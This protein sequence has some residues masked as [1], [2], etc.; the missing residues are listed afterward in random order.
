MKT[1]HKMLKNIFLICAGSLV[2]SAAFTACSVP[3]QLTTPA[4]PEFPANYGLRQADTTQSETIQWKNYFKDK[5]LIQLIDYALAHNIEKLIADQRAYAMRAQFIMSRNYMLPSVNAA[6]STGVTRFGD[7]TIDGVGNFDS[8]RSTNISEKQRIPQPVPDFMIGFTTE[9]EVNLAGKLRNRKKAAYQRW[10]AGEE[11][12][13]LIATQ[14]VSEVARLY[15]ELLALDTELEIIRKNIGIQERALEVVDIQKQSGR[16]NEAGVKQFK[17]LLLKAKA[18]EVEV[19]Q[20]IVVVEN[21][22][23]SLMGRY[24][25]RVV[26][27]DTID[28]NDLPQLLKVG[29]PA[30][31]ISNRP[32]VRAAEREFFATRYDLKAARAAFYPN[33]MIN[34]NFGLNAFSSDLLFETPASLAYMLIG[35]LTMPLINRNQITAHYR[36]AFVTSNQSFFQFQRAMLKGVEEV[37]TEFNKLQNYKR[38]AEFKLQEVSELKQAVDISNELFLTGYASYMEVLLTRQNRLESE[39]QLT[40]A[41]K[42]QFMAAIQLYKA[43]GGGW[44]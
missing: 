41:N 42:E 35:G 37:N 43:L 34:G 32:D 13:H 3:Q 40:E 27:K 22:L 15:Y 24:P 30:N 23:N 44:R 1:R 39:L 31:L 6:T 12:R 14:V 33:I 2:L 28:V 8:N 5:A 18:L 16:I 29:V 11:G 26:R 4:S 25:Q 19:Q 38:V 20:E 9:W 17:A 36:N 21:S 10:M 7:Y